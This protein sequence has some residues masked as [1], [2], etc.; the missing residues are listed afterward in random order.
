MK[1]WIEKGNVKNLVALDLDR[2]ENISEEALVKLIKMQG[3]SLRG[4][5]LSNIPHITEHFWNVMLPSLR[6]SR[7]YFYG[8]I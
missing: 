6:N 8:Y 1:E 4:L 3:P 2:N 5:G 7:Y